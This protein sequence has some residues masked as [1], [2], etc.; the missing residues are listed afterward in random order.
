[1]S[2][3]AYII[4]AARA[5]NLRQFLIWKKNHISLDEISLDVVATGFYFLLVL[6]LLFGSI[7]AQ[8]QAQKTPVEWEGCEFRLLFV[9]TTTKN[10]LSTSRI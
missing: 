10:N 1:M 2:V 3:V 8:E 5:A 7:L 4:D 6:G 9:I